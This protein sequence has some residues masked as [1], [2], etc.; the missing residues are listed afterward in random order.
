MK[1]LKEV[2]P[3]K[4]AATINDIAKKIGISKATVSHAI[5]KTRPVSPITL[6]KIEKAMIELNYRPNLLARS[7]SKG[8]TNTLG[9][10]LSDIKN[11]DNLELVSSVEKMI[12]KNNYNLFLVDIGLDLK[13]GI[14]N[15][16]ALI[17]KRVDG[18]ICVVSL[19]N[20]VIIKHLQDSNIPFVLIDYDK[21]EADFDFTY[22][23]YK[24]GIYEAVNHLVEYGHKKIYFISG[25]LELN[26]A[27][28][29]ENIFINEIKSY[30]K[31][32]YRIFSSD[33]TFKGGVNSAKEII[34]SGDIPTAVICSNDFS[35]IGVLRKFIST[36]YKVPED[37]S[38]IGIDNNPLLCDISIPKLTSINTYRLI[39]G[40]E[41]YRMIIRSINNPNKV[42]EK[43]IIVTKLIIRESTGK[44]RE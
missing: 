4:K 5:N 34:K 35:A 16:D 20:I 10:V 13:M 36:G 2:K 39:T 18:I 1:R 26:T 32:R 9:L 11:P 42:P 19:A 29:R 22:V 28:E 15:V 33:H 38:I 7:L 12:N 14:K 30:P 37:I 43:K 31:V 41:A 27:K 21:T 40:K 17:N 44:Y 24:I 6:R 3:Q 8:R 25:P 23:D